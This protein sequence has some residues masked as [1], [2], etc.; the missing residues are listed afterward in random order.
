MT[1]TKASRSPQENTGGAIEGL[2]LSGFNTG[3]RTS[4]DKTPSGYNR[5]N[6]NSG[7]GDD[8]FV[9]FKMDSS[10]NIATQPAF[11]SET[12][13]FVEE[14][15]RQIDQRNESIS[16]IRSDISR[17]SQRISMLRENMDRINSIEREVSQIQS[18]V[19]M[20][21]S[22]E[23]LNKRVEQEASKQ[24]NERI[25]APLLFGT[26]FV[27]LIAALGTLLTGAWLLFA[28]LIP[29]PLM[30]GYYLWRSR[31]I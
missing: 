8:Q 10:D 26:A 12:S 20:S 30:T 3:T 17:N 23:E 6:I 9:L 24:I 16:D 7:E 31:N 27:L 21:V 5:L 2:D 11:S 1:R 28:V 18:D 25:V 4:S 13:E 29:I 15:V 22:T 19:N 14:F